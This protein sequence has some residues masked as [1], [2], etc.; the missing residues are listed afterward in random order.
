MLNTDRIDVEFT[1]TFLELNALIWVAHF[2][3]QEGSGR[4]EVL[5][6]QVRIYDGPQARTRWH[7]SPKFM[8]SIQF[9][10]ANVI[11]S[12][13]IYAPFTADD[14]LRE[15]AILELRAFKCVKHGAVSYFEKPTT[16]A[17]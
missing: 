8:G 1:Y 14:I 15:L 5:P 16:N 9:N 12:V 4:Y 11:V 2:D 3:D 13:D 6:G 10:D 7:I 17:H